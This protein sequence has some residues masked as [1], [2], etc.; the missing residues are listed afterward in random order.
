MLPKE[1][2]ELNFDPWVCL[3][4]AD[5]KK[6]QYVTAVS[7]GICKQAVPSRIATQPL[8]SKGARNRNEVLQAK[9]IPKQ[10][11]KTQTD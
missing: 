2:F 11:L 6:G 7:T 4:N 3:V 1:L 9:G 10:R 5:F 8:S